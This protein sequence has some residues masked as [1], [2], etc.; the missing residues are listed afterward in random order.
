[1]SVTTST[2]T[3]AGTYT[4]T[5]TGTSGSLVHSTTV[6]L[7][8]NPAPVPDFT[9]TASPATL[10][11]ARQSS[12]NYTVTITG[13]NGFGGTVN[14]SASG[15]EPRTS[16]SF[17]PASVTGS[18]TSTLTVNARR[19]AAVGTLTLTITGTS[20]ALSHSTNVTLTIQ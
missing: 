16:G 17:N 2:T 20:G 10:T 3:P 9:I 12:G 6:T 18:G 19:N 14:L 11:V 1:M 13:V 7:V 4:L 5:I 8:V 15:F